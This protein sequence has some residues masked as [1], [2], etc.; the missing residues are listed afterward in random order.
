MNTNNMAFEEH[1]EG[2]TSERRAK[3][4]QLKN[5]TLL[6]ERYRIGDVLGQGGFGITYSGYDERLK[7]RIAIKEYYPVGYASRTTEISNAVTIVDKD[8]KKFIQNGMERFLSEAKSLAKFQQYSGIV[9]VRDFFEENETAYIVMELLE[10]VDLKYMIKRKLFTADEIFSMLEPVF[11]ALIRVHAEGI[12]HRDIS[13]DNIFILNNGSAKLMD[14]GAARETNLE[15]QRSISIVLKN[16][17]APEEQYRAKGIQGPWT[18]IYALCA[19][20]YKCITGNTPEGSLER[21]RHDELKKPSELDVVIDTNL[22]KVLMKGL[23]VNP[24]NRFQS[25]A[26]MKRAISGDW[27]GIEVNPDEDDDEDDESTVAITEN[28]ETVNNKQDEKIA[29]DKKRVAVMGVVLAA[30]IIVIVSGILLLNR[31]NDITSEDTA[32]PNGTTQKVDNTPAGETVRAVGS[33]DESEMVDSEDSNADM[34]EVIFTPSTEMT[35]NEFNE[36]SEVIKGR[37]EA[38]LCEDDVE[39]EIEGTN[40]K[41]Y[42]PKETFSSQESMIDL[43][44]WNVSNVFDCAAIFQYEDEEGNVDYENLDDLNAAI[45]SFELEKGI[46]SSLDIEDVV[47]DESFSYDGGDYTYIRM[48]L[49]DEYWEKYGEAIKKGTARFYFMSFDT[50]VFGSIS[51]IEY[52]TAY[53]SDGV[54]G[55]YIESGIEWEQLSGKPCLINAFYHNMTTN[56]IDRAFKTYSPWNNIVW[57]NAGDAEIHGNNQCDLSELGDEYIISKYEC[58]TYMSEGEYYDLIKAIKGRLDSIGAKYAFGR[59]I[60]NGPEPED[61]KTYDNYVLIAIDP[62]YCGDIVNRYLT[63]NSRYSLCAGEYYIDIDDSNLELKYDGEKPYLEYKFRDFYAKGFEYFTRYMIEQGNET[64]YLG[65]GSSY[66]ANGFLKTSIQKPIADGIIR[67]DELVYET[68]GDWQWN[69]IEGLFDESIRYE[70]IDRCFSYF[71]SQYPNSEGV[72]DAESIGAKPRFDLKKEEEDIRQ[73]ICSSV[74]LS[75]DVDDYDDGLNAGEHEDLYIRLNLNIND[76]FAD[77]T[78]ET[79]HEIMSKFN[80]NDYGYLRHIYFVPVQTDGF[81]GEEFT[82]DWVRH[83]HS[84]ELQIDENMTFDNYIKL[85]N[86][87]KESSIIPFV[88]VTVNMSNGRLEPYV[89]QFKKL[90]REDE[91]LK[92]YPIMF[93]GGKI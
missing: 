6:K 2:I 92:G 68:E 75:Y 49:T 31:K 20:I 18:D 76:D 40:I 70:G 73:N 72:Y 25:V 10:G 44:N 1:S 29:N 83:S 63:T 22:E 85:L 50:T 3:S 62:E 33:E 30:V 43:V 12:I 19:T 11:D 8:Q 9:S 47:Y 7:I 57:E 51:G 69:M 81:T 48:G 26:D 52:G 67:F 74:E 84:P 59:E 39:I 5:G 60:M 65:I 37:L 89:D 93:N 17:Y 77:N 42:L 45:E 41:A 61:E 56:N 36:S 21:V 35:I 90:M 58:Y 88:D 86:S 14:F 38:L 79:V 54:L 87:K 46:I 27:E 4:H 24:A 66:S 16:G 32:E 15:D 78:A 71:G 82:I 34:Y 55:V 64:I 80:L 23:S 28:T 91:L 13:P 53:I